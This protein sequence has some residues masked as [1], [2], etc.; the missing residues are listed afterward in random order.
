MV[1]VPFL[2]GQDRRSARQVLVDR[3]LKVKIEVEESDKPLNEVIRT[4]PTAYREVRAGSTVTLFVSDG[5]ETIPDV[6]GMKQRRAVQVLTEA[7]FEPDVVEDSNT[8]EPKGTVIRQ[9]P[10]A[11]DEASDGATVTIVVS[12]YE[13][14]EP[15]PDPTP[16]ESGSPS[17]SPTPPTGTPGPPDPL[18]TP[19]DP[20]RRE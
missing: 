12:T 5:P 20:L 9:S 17:P 8:T 1:E 18:P 11:G 3:D 4:E 10:R 16:D 13:E 14:P 19:P 7:R 6:V 15:S 2:T